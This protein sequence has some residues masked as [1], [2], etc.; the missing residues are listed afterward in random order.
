MLCTCGTKAVQQAKAGNQASQETA[1]SGSSQNQGWTQPPSLT[2]AGAATALAQQTADS[3]PSNTTDS[4]ATRLAGTSYRAGLTAYS[5]QASLQN[6][7]N[8]VSLSA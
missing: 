7:V 6:A 2:A 3:R 5:R 4:S 8:S 1:K